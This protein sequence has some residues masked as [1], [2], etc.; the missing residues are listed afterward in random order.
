[1]TDIHICGQCHSHFTSISS[2]VEHKRK[3]CTPAP[4]STS[5]L[6]PDLDVSGTPPPSTP[7]PSTGGKR[8]QEA[9]RPEV[10]SQAGAAA[11]AAVRGQSS[12]QETSLASSSSPLPQAR[13]GKRIVSSPQITPEAS[14]QLS[15]PTPVKRYKCTHDGCGF[16]TAHFKDMQRHI[17]IHTGEKPYTCHYCEKKFSRQDKLKIHHRIHSGDKPFKCNVCEYACVDGGSLKKHM[18]IHNDERP[19]KCQIC[20]Y[21]SRNSS[22]LIVHLRTHTGDTPFH[23]QECDAKFKINSDLTRHMRTHTGDKPFHCKECDYKSSLKSNLN[24]HIKTNHENEKR[25]Q[26]DECGFAC[27]TKR[28]MKQHSHSH[29]TTKPIK[30]LECNFQCYNKVVFRR[31]ERKHS[32]DRPYKCKYCDFDSKYPG[33]VPV[34]VKKRHPETIK[35]KCNRKTRGGKSKASASGADGSLQLVAKKPFQC[36]KCNATFMRQD[37]LFSHKRQHERVSIGNRE[38]ASTN[39]ESMDKESRDRESMAYAMVQLQ[40]YSGKNPSSSTQNSNTTVDVTTDG[41]ADKPPASQGVGSARLSQRSS[42]PT[43]QPDKIQMTTADC[44][45]QEEVVEV[46]QFATDALSE[47]EVSSDNP[48]DGTSESAGEVCNSLMIVQT[49]SNKDP[50]SSETITFEV[51]EED[52]VL[53]QIPSSGTP[54]TH[55]ASEVAVA[56]VHSPSKAVVHTSEGNK[57]MHYFQVE[58]PLLSSGVGTTVSQGQSTVDAIRLQTTTSPVGQT[59]TVPQHVFNVIQSQLAQQQMVTSTQQVNY[60]TPAIAVSQQPSFLI[61]QQQQQQQENQEQQPG[62]EGNSQVSTDLWPL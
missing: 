19:F 24:H 46:I 37:S 22:Q 25:F 20:E 15:R 26:C 29:T 34:H 61:T 10:T 55:G 41:S 51:Q 52:I 6:I 56:V 14:P 23:C 31:H 13:T 8:R 57:E 21:R 12:S 30:C 33:H 32:D 38:G 18:R 2:F 50:N 4:A 47:V 58:T 3:G 36:D 16:T 28:Q 9:N 49:Q 43:E 45:I 11:A 35:Q 7:P 42:L 59:I 27:C 5:V 54:N 62:G 60:A 40:Q 44:D 53:A 1:M 17:R 39:T 48:K